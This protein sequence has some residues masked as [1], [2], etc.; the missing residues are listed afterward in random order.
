[1]YIRRFS[2]SR[3]KPLPLIFCV[4]PLRQS[5]EEYFH[6]TIKRKYV[7]HQVSI[8]CRRTPWNVAFGSC[9][10]FAAPTFS[11][12]AQRWAAFRRWNCQS[13]ILLLW[14]YFSSWC[15][16]DYQFCLGGTCCNFPSD[17]IGCK[18]EECEIIVK[19]IQFA[20]FLFDILQYGHSVFQSDPE[21]FA[22]AVECVISWQFWRRG[23]CTRPDFTNEAVL[24]HVSSDH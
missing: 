9:V 23:A 2:S 11:F 18:D 1:M 20:L 15:L 13:W 14:M 8:S 12:L 6:G 21:T 10:S 17:W 22:H 24:A 19:L 7:L 4:R 3:I 5:A 16:W